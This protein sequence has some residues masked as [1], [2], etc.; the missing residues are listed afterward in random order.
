MR[1]IPSLLYILRTRLQRKNFIFEFYCKG[2]KTLDL[3]CGEGEFLKND[4]ENIYGIDS[5]T[6]VIQCLKEEG[7]KVKEGTVTTLPY[8]D[9]TYEVVYCHNVIEH[10]DVQ[11]A[12]KMLEESS[13]VLTKRGHLVLSSEVVTKKF[14]ETFGHIKPYPPKAVLKLLRSESREEFEGISGLEQVGLFYIGDYYKNN[15]LY[16]F[17]FCIG[18]LIPFLRREY[19]L[20][21]QKK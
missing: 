6:R 20:I 8:E 1:N 4:K 5:N 11:T 9:D 18:Y 17:T 19:F 16:M 12:Y 13:R 21:L 2:K 3:G 14:W 7:C 10:L 15:L